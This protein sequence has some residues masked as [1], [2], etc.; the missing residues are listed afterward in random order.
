M[1]SSGE[2]TN[3]ALLR[4]AAQGRLDLAIVFC[5]ERRAGRRRAR[6][7]ARRAG[8]R[9][10]G[11]DH[12]LA[13][14]PALRLSDLP[15][16]TVLIAGGRESG[17]FIDRVLGAFEAS[18]LKSRTTPDPE[19]DPDLGLRAVRE[20]IGVVVYVRG[21]GCARVPGSALAALD[22]PPTMPCHLAWRTSSRTR[23]LG[24]ILHAVRAPAP[25]GGVM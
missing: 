15:G 4:D 18:G 25:F 22:R 7:R 16:E 21:C 19:P 2:N 5:A 12:P 10:P 23:A 3:A 17:G 1:L 9:A 8:G 24:A 13:A 11:A 14:R 20:S 6:A